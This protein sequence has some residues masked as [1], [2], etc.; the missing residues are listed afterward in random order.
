MSRPAWSHRARS[1]RGVWPRHNRNDRLYFFI[2]PRLSLTSVH[3]MDP[4]RDNR[5]RHRF[6]RPRPS[7]RSLGIAEIG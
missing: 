5:C 3:L 6:A 4:E 2:V 7:K 1:A